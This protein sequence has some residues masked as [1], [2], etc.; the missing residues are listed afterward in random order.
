MRVFEQ[1]S[2]FL[3]VGYEAFPGYLFVP[4]ALPMIQRTSTCLFPCLQVS[5]GVFP[6]D[7][8]P[9]MGPFNPIAVI[10]LGSVEEVSAC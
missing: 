4:Q 10:T 8:E 2:S 5:Q 9:V 1:S 6:Y 7:L 3:Y